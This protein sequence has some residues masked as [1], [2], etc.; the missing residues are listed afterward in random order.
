[1]IGMIGLAMWDSDPYDSTFMSSRMISW[2]IT[3]TVCA[4]KRQTDSDQDW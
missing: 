3:R 2:F 1:M 4:A